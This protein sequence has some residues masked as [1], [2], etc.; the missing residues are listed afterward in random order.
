MPEQTRIRKQGRPRSEK[1]KKAVLEAT[2][3]LM[4]A[5]PIR[6]I[7]IEAIAK[8]AGVGK[9]TIYRWW[10]TKCSIVMDAFFMNAS[11]S[12]PSWKSGSPVEALI[13][14]VK[15]MTKLLQ[16]PC[17]KVISEIIG[18]GQSDPP[19]LQEFQQRLLS[20]LQEPAR[21]IIE[22]GKEN[23]EI[24][25]KLDTD[26]ALEIIFGP[27]FCRLLVS[28]ESFDRKFAIAIPRRVVAALRKLSDAK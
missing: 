13:R 28:S 22:A 8:E 1:S 6:K 20:R 11:L 10:D 14:Q 26:L 23:G 27:A 21:T 12:M 25:P 5:M 18:E 7:S 19:I 16:G 17:G 9:P 3:R 15:S 4:Q 24:D 2:V